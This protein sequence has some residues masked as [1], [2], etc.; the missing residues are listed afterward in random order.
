M[1]PSSITPHSYKQNARSPVFRS[2]DKDPSLLCFAFYTRDFL[3]GK[4][5]S[6][7]FPAFPCFNLVVGKEPAISN[8]L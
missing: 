5:Y 8:P 4:N 1:A 6:E 3:E 2:V 7:T